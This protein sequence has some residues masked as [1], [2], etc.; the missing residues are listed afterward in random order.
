[1]TVFDVRPHAEGLIPPSWVRTGREETDLFSHM[2]AGL[3]NMLTLAEEALLTCI[4]KKKQFPNL[5]FYEIAEED[6]DK[7]IPQRFR[8]GLLPEIEKQMKS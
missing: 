4:E 3:D 8:A 2:Q 6:R 5:T 7:Q 1:M